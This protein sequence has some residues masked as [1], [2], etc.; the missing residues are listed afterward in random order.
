M[1]YIRTENG[2]YEVY[3]KSKLYVDE[4]CY[5]VLGK[6]AISE[7]KVIKVSDTIEELCDSI[8]ETC[9]S[10]NRVYDI[11]EFDD[12]FKN[13]AIQK[14]YTNIAVNLNYKCFYGAIW[15]NKGL[16]YVAKMNES[17]E[18]ELL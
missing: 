13:M 11:C 1:K 8:V 14:K 3:E 15:T 18:L 17:G 16:I 9:I 7:K 6:G 2:I 10:G 4:N 5:V 12:M